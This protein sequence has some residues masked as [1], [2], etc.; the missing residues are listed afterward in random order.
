MIV[1]DSSVWIARLRDEKNV[2]AVAKLDTISPGEIL[3]GD[4]VMLEILQ[5]ARDD[6]HAV[7]LERVIQ[8]FRRARML[9]EGVARAASRHFRHLRGHGVTVRKT[10]D[11]IIASFC[12]INRYSLLHIDRDFDQIAKHL[13]LTII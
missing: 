6:D 8:P 11:L 3:L 2:P 10:T 12:I 1:V 9:D 13:P 7:R 5:G 4:L